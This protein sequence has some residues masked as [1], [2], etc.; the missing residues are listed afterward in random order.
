MDQVFLAP[1]TRELR[2]IGANVDA[3]GSGHVWWCRATVAGTI[4]DCTVS[5]TAEQLSGSLVVVTCRASTTISPSITPG[6][7]PVEHDPQGHANGLILLDL[8]NALELAA[9]ALSLCTNPAIL[10]LH[11]VFPIRDAIPTNIAR[12]ALRSVAMVDRASE[13]LRSVLLGSQDPGEAFSRMIEKG[14]RPSS[15]LTDDHPREPA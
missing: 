11:C 12:F 1:I 15:R 2:R 7:D 3:G 14:F 10:S 8:I 6:V 5:V 13:P 9:G 4:S